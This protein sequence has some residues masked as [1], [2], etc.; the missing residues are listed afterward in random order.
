MSKSLSRIS[1]GNHQRTQQGVPNVFLYKV[2]MV[3]ANNQQPYP[4]VHVQFIL[5]P[6]IN[7]KFTNSGLSFSLFYFSFLF[8]IPFYFSIFYLQNNQGQGRLVT[9]SH[10]S[11]PDGVVTRQIMRLGRIQQKIQE[12]ITL[13]NMDTTCWP[14]RLHMVVQGRVYSS[15][16][17]LSIEL[18]K[19][20][21]F[22]KE[23]SIEFSCVTQYKSCSIV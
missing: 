13:Y 8:F 7:V 22:I 6:C 20:D 10:Q 16:H 5:P 11:Q 9:P 14:H 17:R 1:S 4:N 2:L 15:Q 18:Y 12:Q 3:H 23:F 19:V 21:Q